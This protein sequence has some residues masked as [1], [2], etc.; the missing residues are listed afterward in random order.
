MWNHCGM[1]L[2]TVSRKLIIVKM[3]NTAFVS[4]I[5]FIVAILRIDDISAETEVKC[6][7]V[8]Q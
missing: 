1:I 5:A 3:N 7:A 2:L 8:F 6:D 4:G